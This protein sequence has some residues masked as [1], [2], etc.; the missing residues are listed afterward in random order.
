MPYSKISELPSTVGKLPTEAKRMWLKAFNKAHADGYSEE[1]AIKIAWSVVKKKYKKQDDTWVIKKTM[2]L[3]TN[4]HKSGLFNPTYSLDLI[5]ASTGLDAQGQ[6]VSDSLLERAFSGGLIDTEGDIDHLDLNTGNDWTTGLFKSVKQFYKDGKLHIKAIA[7]K[8]H[9][10]YKW[11]ID[12][13]IYR[14]IKG[15]SAEYINPIVD[16]NKIID[17]ERIG[18]TVAIKDGPVNPDARIKR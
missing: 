11:F 9:K 7:D 12:N 17:A 1:Q 4:I 13:K 5:V 18:W 6:E 3:E 8:T 15:A 14:H 2:S 16:G 10:A